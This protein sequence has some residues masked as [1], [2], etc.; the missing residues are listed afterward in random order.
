MNIQLNF[1]SLT[2]KLYQLAGPCLYTR[3]I[4]HSLRTGYQSILV[5]TVFENTRAGQPERRLPPAPIRTLE[6]S[7]RLSG[8]RRT[9]ITQPRSTTEHERQ[10]VTPY[11]RLNFTKYIYPPH[12]SIFGHRAILVRR[13]RGMAEGFL[14]ENRTIPSIQCS[15]LWL[16][17]VRYWKTLTA[18]VVMA[19]SVQIR[20]ER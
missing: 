19:L 8:Q 18:S 13:E 7:S 4:F 16:M 20:L 9:L 15:A 2:K 17:V 3:T 1:V 14:F 10:L 12:L 5:L 11:R 6:W